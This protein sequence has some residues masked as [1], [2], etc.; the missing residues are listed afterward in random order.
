L[1]GLDLLVFSGGVGE[2][3]PLIRSKICEEL[4]F[5]G[6]EI[7]E[8][9]NHGLQGEGAIGKE[10]GRASIVVVK[11]DE[12]LVIAR[13]A[14]HQVIAAEMLCEPY[15]VKS[16]STCSIPDLLQHSM[17]QKMRR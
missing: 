4:A 11:T 16:V 3:V 10:G 6:L 12:E 15:F 2:N 14:Y 17:R 9:K 5:L 13:E 1:G 7:D 8:T